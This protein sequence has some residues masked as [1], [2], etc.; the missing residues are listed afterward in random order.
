MHS[1]VTPIKF[2]KNNYS[3]AIRD[4]KLC[5]FEFSIDRCFSEHPVTAMV[6]NITNFRGFRA[7]LY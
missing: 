5:C 2:S 7:P 3:L 4:S 1:A 6:E